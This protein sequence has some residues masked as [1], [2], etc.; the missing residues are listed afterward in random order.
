MTKKYKQHPLTKLSDEELDT[1]LNSLG[2]PYTEENTDRIIKKF[3]TRTK[4][5]RVIFRFVSMSKRQLVLVILMLMAFIPLTAIAAQRIWQVT[6]EKEEYKLVTKLDKEGEA[7]TGE[8]YYKVKLGYVPEG[9]SEGDPDAGDYVSNM[10]KNDTGNEWI[11]FNLCY[12]DNTDELFDTFVQDY[13]D[14][15]IKNMSAWK[16]TTSYEEGFVSERVRVFYEKENLFIEYDFSESFSEKEIKKIIENVS[17]KETSNIEEAT[18]WITPTTE[19]EYAGYDESD[20]EVKN[21]VLDPNSPDVHQVGDTVAVDWTGHVDIPPVPEGME[22]PNYERYEITVNEVAW[23]NAVPEDKFAILKKQYETSYEEINGS[24]KTDYEKFESYSMLYETIPFLDKEGKANTMDATE[25]LTGDGKET[26]SRPVGKT[27]IIPKYLE[28][29]VTVKSLSDEPYEWLQLKPT[30]DQFK[31]E[32]QGFK[33]EKERY[34]RI[35]EEWALYPFSHFQIPF[36]NIGVWGEEEYGVENLQPGE[37]RDVTL[38]YVVVA[39]NF[40][41]IF[42]N[43]KREMIEAVARNDQYDDVDRSTEWI[44]ITE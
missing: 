40:D 22:E 25:I 7:K 44:Q 14:M 39:E 43:L 38:S 10:F 21:W 16:I 31:L 15:K 28:L 9:F 27:K 30:L 26:I 19:E 36:N 29:D 23:K 34:F 42:L 8:R 5:K 41:H 33:I 17:L 2:H 20:E 35:S 1:L 18:V 32:D 24:K 11:Y 4:K 6:M 37:S 13:R 12:L 3:K